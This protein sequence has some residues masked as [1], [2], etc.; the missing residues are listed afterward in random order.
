MFKMRK[1]TIVLILT[2]IGLCLLILL[3]RVIGLDQFV[4]VDEPDWLK[5]GAN[6]Y[7]ALGQRNFAST[8]YFNHPAVTTMWI[9]T[10]A[11]LW[12]FRAYRG[13]GQGYFWDGFKF[14]NFL[15][16]FHKQPLVLLECS[17]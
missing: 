5:Y 6:F 15:Q 14:D 8:I 13:L 7:Y 16:E 10:A 11:F 12:Y 3:P 17:R 4:S 1:Q 2:L 9:V